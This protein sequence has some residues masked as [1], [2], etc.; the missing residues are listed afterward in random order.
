MSMAPDQRP[1]RTKHAW[2]RVGLWGLLILVLVATILAAGY[3]WHL[4]TSYNKAQKLSSAEAFPAQ[5]ERPSPI[6]QPGDTSK[7]PVNILLLGSDENFAPGQDAVLSRGSRSDTIML[8]NI[9]ADRKSVNLLSIMRDNWVE[10]P[11][12][13][14]NKIN[15][16][17]SYGGPALTVAS[18]EKLLDVRIDHIALIDLDGL[19]G[20]TDAVGGVT[21]ETPR[22]EYSLNGE[23]ALDFVRGRSFPDGDYMRVHNQQ[24]FLLA[25]SNKILS[26]DVLLNPETIRNFITA[27]APY[28][29]VD[30]NLSLSVLI[31]LGLDLGR[32]YVVNG[33]I[34]PNLGIGVEDGQSVV[35]P[36]YAGLAE[37][38]RHLRE[39]TLQDYQS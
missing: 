2:W 1:L 27:A 22:G 8:M 12:H 32:D 11:G 24:L 4:T 20:I 26:S 25:L 6:D 35:Y 9:S 3:G 17:F 14:M 19:K 5:H 13:G 39:D 21:V 38:S 28:V 37:V 34:S 15:A 23:E 33:F 36:D 29:T 10:I 30:E 31:T 18:V 7:E 16:A